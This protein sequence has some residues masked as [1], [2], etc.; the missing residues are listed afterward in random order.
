MEMPGR[1]YN[2]GS[3]RYGFNGK[4]D[5]NDITNGGQDYGI[6]IYDKR[7]GRFLS[8]DPITAIYPELTP[9]QFASNRPVDGIDM[10]GL[11]F[12]STEAE[13]AYH[14]TNPFL[15]LPLA[16]VSPSSIQPPNT[17]H[18]VNHAQQ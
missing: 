16:P 9:Y 6:R 3:C 12:K 17:D 18:P 2:A 4:E 5:D 7:L 11:E 1:G 8:V 14:H 13:N 10:D 15:T